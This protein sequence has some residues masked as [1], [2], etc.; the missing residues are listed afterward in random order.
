MAWAGCLCPRA[1]RR[2]PPLIEPY[3]V[4]GLHALSLL[5]TGQSWCCHSHFPDEPTGWGLKWDKCWALSLACPMTGTGLGFQL[6]PFWSQAGS[7]PGHWLPLGSQARYPTWEMHTL[8]LVRASARAPHHRTHQLL[9][10]QRSQ[11]SLSSIPWTTTL[12]STE[13][14]PPHVRSPPAHQEEF[15]SFSAMFPWCLAEPALG[16]CIVLCLMLYQR[17]CNC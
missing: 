11:D 14:A 2:D 10:F 17:P 4:P 7:H 15:I 12:K 6:R 3:C 5:T 8:P 16:P 13:N 1:R 9:R